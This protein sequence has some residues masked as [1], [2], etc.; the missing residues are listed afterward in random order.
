MARQGRPWPRSSTHPNQLSLFKFKCKHSSADRRD[1]VPSTYNL[2][3]MQVLKIEEE[4]ISNK[5]DYNPTFYFNKMDFLPN[6]KLKKKNQGNHQN[7]LYKNH[8]NPL[9]TTRKKIPQN[10]HIGPQ[11]KPQTNY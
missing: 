2:I 11:E 3:L 6:S 7:C 9:I 10:N 1:N 5:I 4:I 8:Q